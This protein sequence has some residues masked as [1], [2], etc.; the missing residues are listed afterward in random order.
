[1]NRFSATTTS[2]AVVAAPPERIW[3]VLTDPVLLPKL[4]PLLD[5]IDADGDLWT[6]HMMPILGLGVR[7]VPAFTEQM[8]FV[9]N[10]RIDYHHAPPE[11]THERTG[12]D[13]WYVL[14]PVDGGTRLSISLTLD[15][16]LPLPRAA[17]PA[18]QRV[19]T[20]TIERT[21]VRFSKNLLEHLGTHQIGAT[22]LR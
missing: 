14:E 7:V 8:T 13:G 2:E 17:G 3:A 21:G 15:V 11:G 6:W 16:E 20:S 9:E 1:M 22:T 5:R 19:M 12:A 4:T 18:V 10:A